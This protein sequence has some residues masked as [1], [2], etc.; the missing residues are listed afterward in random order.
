LGL[1]IVLDHGGGY[2]TLYGHN[3]QLFRKVGD[4][5]KAGDVLSAV[6]DAAGF[7]QTGLYVE[8]RKGKEA[9]N[10]ADWLAKK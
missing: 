10:P 6:G 5:V 9:L 4:R 8:I 1:L 2:M 3:E 7:G